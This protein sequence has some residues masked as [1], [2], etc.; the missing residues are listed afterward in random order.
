[1]CR[2]GEPHN[3]VS[4]SALC[5]DALVCI[6]VYTY[7]QMQGE[8]VVGPACIVNIKIWQ[9]MQVFP[10]P[11]D[12]CSPFLACCLECPAIWQL[13]CLLVLLLPLTDGRAKHLSMVLVTKGM[14]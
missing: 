9:T 6:A 5:I 1:M 7:S 13:L 14:L 4:D 8:L 3:C 11:S 10:G 12:L 2:T